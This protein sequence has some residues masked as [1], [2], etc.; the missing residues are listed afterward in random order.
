[1]N[2]P[3]LPPS[4]KPQGVN[5]LGQGPLRNGNY[6]GN[7]NAAPRCGAKTR[8]GCPCK[9]PAMPNGRCRMHGG[10]TPRHTEDAKTRIAA[11]RLS[12]NG[13][14]MSVR[15]M[16]AN[17][18]HLIRQCRIMSARKRMGLHLHDLGPLIRAVQGV[19]ATP[20]DR[21]DECI[22]VADAFCVARQSG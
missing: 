2:T 8:A 4:A 14:G 18:G 15:A 22:F 12:Q 11:A 9:G 16:L 13:L 10:A 19:D 1:M 20:G 17:N 5:P 3:D 7:P 6:R 21:W